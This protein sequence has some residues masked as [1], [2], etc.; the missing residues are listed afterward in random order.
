MFSV[1]VPFQILHGQI[2]R[3]LN[4]ALNCFRRRLIC[5]VILWYSSGHWTTL[6]WFPS[7]VHELACSKCFF[8]Q[9]LYLLKSRGKSAGV[10]VNYSVALIWR[11]SQALFYLSN[12]LRA[13]VYYIVEVFSAFQK[14]FSFFLSVLMIFFFF[15]VHPRALLKKKTGAWECE[16]F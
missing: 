2:C 5:T 16:Q 12:I 8:Q 15:T 7:S 4:S 11:H 1:S 13:C 6:K 9:V 10:D 14:F 3:T